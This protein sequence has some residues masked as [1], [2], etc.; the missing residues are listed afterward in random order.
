VQRKLVCVWGG[1]AEYFLPY[2]GM[3]CSHGKTLY[4]NYIVIFY[5][6]ENS[7]WKSIHLRCI[8]M[9]EEITGPDSLKPKPSAW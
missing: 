3:L 2:L 9:E 4:T 1:G 8:R 6:Y 5:F 7:K